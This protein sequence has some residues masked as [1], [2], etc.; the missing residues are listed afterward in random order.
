MDGGGLAS[1]RAGLGGG[2]LGKGVAALVLV[3]FGWCLM[4]QGEHVLSAFLQGTTR[5]AVGIGMVWQQRRHLPL[6]W[7]A[8]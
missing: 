3:C 8:Q 2:H 6:C 5:K 4:Q 7:V 1:Q